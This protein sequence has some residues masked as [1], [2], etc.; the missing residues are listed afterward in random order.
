[1]G[2]GI[3][4]A[5]RRF[6]HRNFMLDDDGM[7]LHMDRTIKVGRRFVARPLVV[8]PGAF[9]ET[10]MTA[11]HRDALA[12]HFDAVRTTRRIALYYFW[13]TMAADIADFVRGCPDCQRTAWGLRH[14]RYPLGTTPVATP[15]ATLLIDI[16][17][18][19][20]LTTNNH[21]YILVMQ[22]RLTKWPE[23]FPLQN[24]GATDVARVLVQEII[25]RHGCP[26][27]ILSDNGDEFDNRLNKEIC[28]WL[29]ARRV[30]T[31]KYNPAANAVERQNRTMLKVLTHMVNASKTN[32]DVHLSM[33][34]FAIRTA[35]NIETQETPFFAMYGRDPRLPIDVALLAP[36]DTEDC[37][38]T[39]QR[40]KEEACRA[41]GLAREL[42]KYNMRR[43]QLA[44]K[45]SSALDSDCPNFAVGDV[46][47]L[48][49]RPRRLPGDD[50][51]KL[52]VVFRGPYRISRV[53]PNNKLVL[54]RTDG[55]IKGGLVL[56]KHVRRWYTR[57]GQPVWP[58]AETPYYEG[59]D[60]R[61]YGP[62]HP[63]PDDG[64]REEE[65][66]TQAVIEGM[67]RR[68]L[69]QLK[70][71]GVVDSEQLF[72]LLRQWG[73]KQY[74]QRLKV[75]PAEVEDIVAWWEKVQRE[76]E[77]NAAD[78][79]LGP[80][81]QARMDTGDVEAQAIQLAL[82]QEPES[83]SCET[84]ADLLADTRN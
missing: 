37:S 29:R 39:F 27:T 36:G 32:W 38:A 54:Q 9:R 45:E 78:E 76:D 28:R 43:G 80:H 81:P 4:E 21:R 10:I 22:C 35:V 14:Y 75:P 68:T 71:R 24:K 6:L 31:S 25:P 12:G 18:P 83:E 30:F 74:L 72:E 59:D 49:I 50:T 51:K 47:Q 40:F 44:R 84:V 65:G 13:D 66:A 62:D 8:V 60:P 69:N 42:A 3:T 55:S 17:G 33:A 15:F 53:Y 79:P 2:E 16:V 26:T 64:G 56:A 48:M 57:K 11:Y 23:L 7:L 19:L 5:Q 82:G 20:P 70:R 52:A 58:P 73:P 63:V 34:A 77:R 41:L 46:V 1:M 61:G 67:S